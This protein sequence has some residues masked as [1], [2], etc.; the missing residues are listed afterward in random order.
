MWEADERAPIAECT[1]G[2]R[3]SIVGVRPTGLDGLG[4]QINVPPTS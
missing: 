3:R 2:D 4:A 1:E